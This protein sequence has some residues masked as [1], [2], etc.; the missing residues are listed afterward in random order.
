[1]VSGRWLAVGG[2]RS[3][4]SGRWSVVGGRW[5]VVSGQRL[6]IHAARGKKMDGSH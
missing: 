2:W 3:V 5:S 1:M 6:H 4:V